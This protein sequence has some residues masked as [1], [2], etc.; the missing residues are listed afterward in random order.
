MIVVVGWILW[1]LA[2][3]WWVWVFFA[4]WCSYYYG[5]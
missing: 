5:R 3:P 4:L 2:A 1:T